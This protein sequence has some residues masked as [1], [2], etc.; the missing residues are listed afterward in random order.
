MLEPIRMTQRLRS[1]LWAAAGVWAATFTACAA[2]ES[3]DP[4]VSA[5]ASGGAGGQDAASTGG[6]GTGGVI[7][8]PDASQADDTG[9]P[10]CEAVNVQADRLPLT[11]YVLYDR[12]ASM[13]DGSKWANARQGFEQFVDDPASED[14]TLGLVFLP[15]EPLLPNEPACSFKNYEQPDVDF[16]T[17]PAQAQ[18]LL[19]GIDATT[20]SGA[21]TPLYPALGGGLNRLIARSNDAAAQGIAENFAI[22]LVTDGKPQAPPTTCSQDPLST[23]NIA[24]LAANGFGKFGIRTFVVGLP[25]TD[26]TFANAVAVAGGTG[27]AIQVSQTDIAESFR[28]ALASIRGEALGCEFPL[29]PQTPGS[30]YSVGKVNVTYVSGPPNSQT[31]KA[32]KSADCTDPMGWHYDNETNP[33]TIVLCSALCDAVK[34][35]GLAQIQIEL[36]C[37]TRVK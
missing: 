27:Q 33:K 31:L 26:Q 29:P 20:A 2:N 22:L 13:A 8:V 35:D 3:P 36:G 37:P 21:G 11:L 25:G 14:I 23:D 9:F 12:S 1:T 10:V 18:A 17:L 7:S 6:G 16:G 24:Q 4:S 5:G 32:F 28:Q 15:R 19:D 30:E 34:A